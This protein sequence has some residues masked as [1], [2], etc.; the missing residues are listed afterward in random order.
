M[1]ERFTRR[2]RQA[3]A[4]AQEEATSLGHNFLGTEHILLGLL[5]EP[6]GVAAGVLGACGVSYEAARRTVLAILGSDP[7][8]VGLRDADALATIG[9]DLEAVR[10][11]VEEAFGEGALER[12]RLGR[13][14]REA[15]RNSRHERRRSSNCRSVRPSV[16]ATATSG[17]STS[18]WR[19]SAS[20][21]ASPT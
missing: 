9:I 2:A 5:R 11:S 14:G 4:T 18:S 10:S 7:E 3:L 6:H 1:F 12:S 21:R 15:R 19:F 16:S 13:N 20:G 8:G 17:P